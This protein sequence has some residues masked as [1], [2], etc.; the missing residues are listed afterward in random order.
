MKPVLINR[1]Y[2]PI[3]EMHAY[4]RKQM[5]AITVRAVIINRGKLRIYDT[6]S[7]IL[8]SHRELL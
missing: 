4:T 7:N 8:K 6:H 1:Y 3:Q 5:L 2:A